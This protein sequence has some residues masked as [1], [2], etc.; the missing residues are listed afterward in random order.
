MR[1][2]NSSLTKDFV[3]NL[4]SGVS[5]GWDEAKKSW[6]ESGLTPSASQNKFKALLDEMLAKAPALPIS[7][8][9]N[10]KDGD[11]L[12]GTN[13]YKQE[14]TAFEK[15]GFVMGGNNSLQ[16]SSRQ[17]ADHTRGILTEIR[18]IRSGHG[19]AGLSPW[20]DLI[21]GPLLNR[22]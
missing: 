19:M 22:V 6:K 7:N 14:F 8:G 21:G 18:A 5:T 15:M 16:D 17:T 1:A 10:K 11:G 20:T 4:I 3:K 2:A 9:F 12:G 13:H